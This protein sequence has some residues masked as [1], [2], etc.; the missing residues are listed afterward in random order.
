MPS[1]TAWKRI[2][3]LASPRVPASKY[4]SPSVAE[5]V[6]VSPKKHLSTTF[7]DFSRTF[8]FPKKTPFA[9]PSGYLYTRPF[10]MQHQMEGGKRAGI[11]PLVFKGG[12]HTRRHYV[13]LYCALRRTALIGIGALL[14]VRTV[15]ADS[16]DWRNV[17]GLNW[18]TSVKSQFEARAGILRR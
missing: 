14:L 8:V 12:S 13:A 18:N 10:S 15:S 17:S 4:R 6:A 7:G 11:L 1:S 3:F 2:N 16:F 9:I 5:S